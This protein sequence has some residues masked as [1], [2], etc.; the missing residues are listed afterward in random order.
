MA[1]VTDV[2]VKDY[3]DTV[4]N[5]LTG[6][7]MRIDEMIGSL[8]RTYGADSEVYGIHSRHLCELAEFIEWKLQILTK[9]CPFDWKGMNKG[10]ES[11]VSVASP[12]KITGPD[13]S[14][15]YVGG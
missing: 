14:G 3:C 11:T 13:F 2:K 12:E 9:V 10:V 6:M 5:D 7:K 15:G 1:T 4:Y 8:E